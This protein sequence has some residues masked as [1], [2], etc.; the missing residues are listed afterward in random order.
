[1]LIVTTTK[2]RRSIQKRLP[3][4]YPQ[5]AFAFH[6]SVQ[7]AEND[8]ARADILITSGNELTEAHIRQAEQLKWMMVISAGLEKMP[9]QTAKKRGIPVTN[10]RGI[11][12]T[13]MAEYAIAMMISATRKIKVW[14]KNEQEHR[15][16]HDLKNMMEISGKTIAILGAGAIGGEIARL[17]K[18]FHMKTL[19]LNRSGR[20]VEHFDEMYTN[21]H[22]NECISQADFVV[23]ILPYT[24]ETEHFLAREQFQAM[25]NETI[26]INIGRGKT[27]NQADLLESLCAGEIAHAVLDVFEEEPLPERHPFWD[28]DQVTV[29]P[30]LSGITPQYQ[31]RAFK[32]FEDNLQ[33]FLNGGSGLI[34]QID[35]DRG[36]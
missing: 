18:A 5:L 25:K 6:E 16:N 7:E 26:F 11:H 30:H 21:E 12:K 3:E 32:I 22:L 14:H 31:H 4:D 1:M 36:Y 15:W 19:G 8:L 17:A 35:Y 34:N 2:I 20:A 27:V 13:P 28:M 29:T 23:A 24:N 10:A 33:I 9:L